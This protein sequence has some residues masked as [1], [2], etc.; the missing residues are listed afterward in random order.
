VLAVLDAALFATARCFQKSPPRL[1]PA[2]DS[3]ARRRA[4]G[5][6]TFREL[7]ELADESHCCKYGDLLGF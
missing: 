2:L 6:L 4:G 5:R 3:R 1:L 7:A